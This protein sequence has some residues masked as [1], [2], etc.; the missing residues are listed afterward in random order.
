MQN[1]TKQ[2]EVTIDE[3]KEKIALADA[4]DSLHRSPAFKK[5]I[6][7]E[8]IQNKPVQL[9]KLTAMPQ[10]EMQKELVHNSMVGISA[11][12]QFFGSVYQD[13][14]AA[15]ESLAEY[16]AALAEEMANV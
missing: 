13:G 2:I 11:I 14:K 6:L 5:L 16:E 1:Q 3:L 9:V 8:Y 7:K 15:K 10:N 4:L 12:Q